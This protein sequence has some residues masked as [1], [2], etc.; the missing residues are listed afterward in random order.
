MR[1]KDEYKDTGMQPQVNKADLAVT[2][3]A[4]E[5]YLRKFCGVVRVPLAYIIRETI[6]V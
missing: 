6:I 1:M 2:M 3:E 4:I 5:K